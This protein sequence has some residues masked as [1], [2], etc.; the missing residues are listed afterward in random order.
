MGK[1]AFHG[2]HLSE[3]STEDKSSSLEAPAENLMIEGGNASHMPFQLTSHR[4]NGKNYLEWAQSVKLAIDGRGKLGH[5]TGETKKPGVGDPKMNSWRSENSLVI[6]WLIN[7]MEP[8]IVRREET[9]RKVMLKPDLNVELKPVI[10]SS[11]LVTVKNGEDKNKRPWCDHCKKYWHTREK[12]W[13]IHGK[14][15][16]WKKKGVDDRGFQSQNGQALQ[17]TYFDQGQQPSPETSP[18]TR[19]QL[20]ILHKLLQSPQFR[21][22]A[23]NSSN[24]SCSFAETGNSKIKIADGSFSAIAG[25]GTIKLSPSLVLHDTLHVP[26]LSCN[27]VS[28][29]KGLGEDDWQC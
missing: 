19:E 4:L 11:A 14:P 3:T 2:E 1:T 29:R 25:K 12:C 20:E 16:N 9:R 24:P 15:L 7:S 8:A 27:L 28:V 26:K 23:Q 21:A 10:D 17:T 5:L 22:N 18:F 13:K 6:A